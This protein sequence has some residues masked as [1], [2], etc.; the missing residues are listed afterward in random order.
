MSD[1]N[2]IDLLED[3]HPVRVYKFVQHLDGTDWTLDALEKGF[4][5]RTIKGWAWILHDQDVGTDHVHVLLWTHKEI[6]PEV[7]ASWFALPGPQAQKVRG[8]KAAIKNELDYMRHQ[9]R[10]SQDLGKVRYPDSAIRTVPGWDWLAFDR[11][12]DERRILSGSSRQRSR[13][14]AQA[15]SRGL[16]VRSALTRST[17]TETRLRRARARYLLAQEPPLFRLAFYMYGSDALLV[18]AIGQGLAEALAGGHDEVF[19]AKDGIDEYDGERVLYWN[20]STSELVPGDDLRGAALVAALDVFPSRTPVSTRFGHTQ[21]IHEFTVISG[22]QPYLRPK[23][24]LG[25]FREFLEAMMNHLAPARL[26][27]LVLVS[28]DELEVQVNAGLLDEG[29]F[30]Q[31]LTLGRFRMNLHKVLAHARGLPEKQRRAVERDATRRQ[32]APVLEARDRVIGAL[33]PSDSPAGESLPSALEHLLA[34]M[35]EE[36][37]T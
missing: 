19:V 14:V 24:P 15:M 4:S 10:S 12:M 34:E 3:K 7:L 33:T 35:G 13:N 28:T 16:S 18:D 22:T 32:V 1:S 21:L 5:H 9:D 25:G 6:S 11:E 26:P 37:A 27:V 17:T 30:D 36:V 31:Y 20:T 8:G 29:T 2:M 23:A